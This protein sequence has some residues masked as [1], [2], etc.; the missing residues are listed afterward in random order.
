MLAANASPATVKD[1]FPGFNQASGMSNALAAPSEG[2]KEESAAPHTAAFIPP[3]VPDHFPTG[4]PAVYTTDATNPYL[5]RVDVS[6][7]GK[8]EKADK[9]YV[10]ARMSEPWVTVII[11]GATKQLQRHLW[12][13]EYVRNRCSDLMYHKFRVFH[14]AKPGARDEWIE[15]DWTSMS[16]GD[17]GRYL[18]TRRHALTQHRGGT[19][20]DSSSLVQVIRPFG[21]LD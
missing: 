9:R 19:G 17:Y 8:L 21:C 15:K 13:W 1:P 5:L 20:S 11:K 10:L 3:P 12:N 4:T 7:T 18:D 2:L 14:R 16:I 6:A